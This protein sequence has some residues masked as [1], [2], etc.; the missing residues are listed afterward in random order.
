ME[1][2]SG[3]PPVMW[4]EGLACAGFTISL[5]QSL[6][7]PIASIILDKISIRQ[8]D[9]IMAAAGHLVEVGEHIFYK[10]AGGKAK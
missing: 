10:P 7:P 3:K 6:N 8:H 9:T 4:L 2:K 1:T 5:T